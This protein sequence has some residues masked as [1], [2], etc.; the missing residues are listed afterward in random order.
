[1]NESIFTEE[2]LQE[3]I[4]E[5]KAALLAASK[6]KSYSIGNRT[7]TMHD[8]P[9]IREQLAWLNTQ[10][11]QLRTGRGASLRFVPAMPRR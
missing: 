10:L 9:Q 5:W 6:R 8:L 3:Q 11:K 7:L 2:E 1:M 4:R